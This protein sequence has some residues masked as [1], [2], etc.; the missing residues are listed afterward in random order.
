MFKRH[1]LIDYEQST[2]AHIF[3]CTQTLLYQKH[4]YK[5]MS[6]DDRIQVTMPK[7][8]KREIR[9]EAAKRDVSMAELVREIL[10][11]EFGEVGNR[12]MMTAPMAD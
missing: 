3:I 5:D 12:T 8:L 4:R 7:E 10:E 11:E 9:V 2:S 6:K 1:V